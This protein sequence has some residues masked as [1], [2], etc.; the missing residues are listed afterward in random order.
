M[1]A[2]QEA[3][4]PC[5]VTSETDVDTEIRKKKEQEWVRDAPVTLQ[6]LRSSI[7]ALSIPV[8]A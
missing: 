6:S 1:L 4:H 7:P 8:L 3:L 5:K 2:G